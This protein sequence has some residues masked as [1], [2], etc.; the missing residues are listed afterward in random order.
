[1]IEKE[2]TKEVQEEQEQEEETKEEAQEPGN[3][4]IS[5]TLMVPRYWYLTHEL[6]SLFLFSILFYTSQ[7]DLPR[8]YPSLKLDL[9]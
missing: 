3:I 6:L 9:D 5:Y 4:I 1:M 7:P 2:E 8:Q